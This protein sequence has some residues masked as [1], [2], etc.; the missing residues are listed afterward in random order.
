[1]QRRPPPRGPLPCDG[2]SPDAARSA[3]PPPA[4][5]QP[6]HLCHVVWRLH[7]LTPW[8]NPRWAFRDSLLVH[9]LSPQLAKEGQ[10]LVAP[11]GQ[12]SMARDNVVRISSH[13][14]VQHPDHFAK[15]PV[16]GSG[17]TPNEISM[18]TLCSDFGQEKRANFEIRFR[19]S[20]QRASGGF[21]VRHL[22]V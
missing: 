14:P 4:R 21:R 8:I 3:S 22:F 17:S 20:C 11:R 5:L 1:V 19:D 6:Q 12:F 15:L 10:F 16:Y 13:G 7:H 2:C 18:P 9:A